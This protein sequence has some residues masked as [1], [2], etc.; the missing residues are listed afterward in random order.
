MKVSIPPEVSKAMM[1]EIIEM[2]AGWGIL[3]GNDID[4]RYA[5]A[6]EIMI[7]VISTFTDEVFRQKAEAQNANG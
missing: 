4:A 2:G 5:K 7:Y 6:E 1:D 3:Y